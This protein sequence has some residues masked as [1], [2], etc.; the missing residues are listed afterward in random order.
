MMNAETERE[1][2]KCRWYK[3]ERK[4]VPDYNH[5]DDARYYEYLARKNISLIPTEEGLRLELLT[6]VMKMCSRMA[7]KEKATK[8]ELDALIKLLKWI[9]YTSAELERGEK[10]KTKHIE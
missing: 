5:R 4:T 8:H 6:D 9:S 2:E 3:S 10:T 7:K 1:L